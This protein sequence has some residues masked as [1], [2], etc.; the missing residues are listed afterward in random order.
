[1]RTIGRTRLR[2]SAPA[3]P[4]ADGRLGTAAASSR[5]SI[6]SPSRTCAGAP[7]AEASDRRLAVAAI[8]KFRRAWLSSV[9]RRPMGRRSDRERKCNVKSLTQH[10]SP[11]KRWPKWNSR[12]PERLVRSELIHNVGDFVERRCRYDPGPGAGRARVRDEAVRRRTRYSRRNFRS[13]CRRGARAPW[14]EWRGQEHLRQA[15]RG[16]LPARRG[17]GLDRRAARGALVA[18]RSLPSRHCRHAPASGPF[19]RSQRRREHLSRSHAEEPLR[20]RG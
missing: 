4:G 1:M 7:K 13:R 5:R 10:C 15:A 2:C 12:R 16:S 19:R 6:S 14:R 17:S 9:G 18:A 11:F 8:S 20:G 3:C